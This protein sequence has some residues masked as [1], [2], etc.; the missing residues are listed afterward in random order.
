[1]DKETY[2]Q[3]RKKAKKYYK[4]KKKL[5]KHINKVQKLSLLIC[6][7]ADTSKTDRRLVKL[8]A[9]LHDIGK[10]KFI[11]TAIGN[12]YDKD[13]HHIY[14][15]EFLKYSERFL[16][17]P[18]FKKTDISSEDKKLICMMVRYHKGSLDYRKYITP[19]EKR[20]IAIVRMADKISKVYK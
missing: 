15:E 11:K 20:L 6:D 17:K 14:G 3:Y 18:F 10:C 9:L 13:K 1:M 4:G 8:G 7:I 2:K 12:D 19:R 5:W 16:E